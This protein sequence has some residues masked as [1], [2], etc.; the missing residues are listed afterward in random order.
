M[1]QETAITESLS[2]SLHRIEYWEVNL[3]SS[4]CTGFTEYKSLIGSSNR[5]A[6]R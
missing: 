5:E 6:A 2:Y 4:E 3:E 1:L